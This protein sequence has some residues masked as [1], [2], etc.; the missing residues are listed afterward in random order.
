MVVPP[1]APP[2]DGRSRALQCAHEGV[3]VP[4]RARR[5]DPPPPEPARLLAPLPR[6]V[7]DDQSLPLVARRAHDGARCA[8]RER[9]SQ[10]RQVLRLVRARDDDRVRARQ[11]L[12]RLAKPAR[13]EER[14]LEGAC[15][16]VDEHDIQVSRQAPV[17]EPVVEHGAVHVA[18]HV[19]AQQGAQ[20]ARAV[21]TDDDGHP[22]EHLAELRG[23]VEAPA[24]RAVA[25]R[26][27]ARHAPVRAQQSHH[28]RRHGR[29]A[30]PAERQIPDGD[31]GYVEPGDPA[32]RVEGAVAPANEGSNDPGRGTPQPR[33]HR[34]RRRRLATAC[35]ADPSRRRRPP[36]S[37]PAPPN[38]AAATSSR[39]PGAP[40]RGSS[41][42][43][44][45]PSP[46]T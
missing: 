20:P 6:S 35:H 22:R 30:R 9:L 33:R 42:A 18:S 32:R 1:D 34:A 45:S 12:D 13:G 2:C 23:L 31:H 43:A 26:R 37:G 44:P 8:A 21:G 41:P 24:L 25:S 7:A 14:V 39:C 40:A 4:D 29:L 16:R 11:R 10:R 15:R 5:D 19:R 36:A 3:R 28:H 17:L 38:G 27:D 46:T